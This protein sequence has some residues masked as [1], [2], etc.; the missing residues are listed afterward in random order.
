[1]LEIHFHSLTLSVLISLLLRP[2]FSLQGTCRAA[3]KCCEGKDT[4]CAVNKKGGLPSLVLDLSD[5]PCYCDQGCLDM[6]DC[7]QDFKDY[8]GVLDCSVSDWSSWSPCSSSCGSGTSSRHRAVIRPESNGGV[9]CP[10]LHQA[11]S[12]TGKEGCPRRKSGHT[13]HD[14]AALRES[15]MILPGKYGQGDQDKYDVRQN[16]KT[17]Q[18]EENDDQYCVVFRVDKS[19]KSCLNRK[20]TKRLRKGS[21]VCVSCESKATRPHLGDRCSGHGVENKTTRFKNVINPGCHGRWT[22]TEVFDKCPCDGGPDF[23]FV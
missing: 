14:S 3:G 20:E 18:E 16:L 5:E 9:S 1:M 21:Q 10:D 22:K 7:C 8:C 2:C 4:D 6:G 23:I 17:F 12:C 11:R 15:A 13:R 19:S